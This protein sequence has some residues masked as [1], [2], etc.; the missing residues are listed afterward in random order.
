MC[1]FVALES[2]DCKPPVKR[3]FLKISRKATFQNIPRHVTEYLRELKNAQIECPKSP[4]TLLKRHSTKDTFQTILN[5]LAVLVG[6]ICG[7]VNIQ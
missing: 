3:E 6:K 1:P 2:V 5:V 7:G 4:F